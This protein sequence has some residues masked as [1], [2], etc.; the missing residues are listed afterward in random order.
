MLWEFPAETI[1]GEW[2]TTCCNILEAVFCRAFRTHHGILELTDVPVSKSKRRFGL[3]IMTPLVQDGIISSFTRIKAKVGPLCSPD[4]QIRHWSAFRGGQKKSSFVAAESPYFQR[5][6]NAIQR[7][8]LGDTSDLLTEIRTSL[9][10]PKKPKECVPEAAGPPFTGSLDAPIGFLL[11]F[12]AASPANNASPTTIK[13]SEKPVVMI[14]WPLQ[15]CH[16]NK[17]NCLVWT[18][19]FRAFTE[20]G[21]GHL[22]GS[23]PD[24]KVKDWHRLLLSESQAKVILLCGPR[25]EDIVR[26]VLGDNITRHKLAIWGF[27]H[28][29]YLQC[30]AE[31]QYRMY[32]RTPALP[33]ET[34]STS[35]GH[36]ARLNEAIKFS[37][38]M[39]GLR[40]IRPYFVE[41]TSAVGYIL[42]CA[43]AERLGE[44][45][46]TSKTIDDG[47]R[48]WLH[49]KGIPE[50]EDI[51]EIERLGG[52]LIRGLLMVLQALPRKNNKEEEKK[53]TQ[54][55]PQVSRGTDITKAER[56]RA[57]E[58][59]DQSCFQNA[60][61][62]VKERIEDR[63]LKYAVSLANLPPELL[64]L[65]ESP[66]SSTAPVADPGAP[67]DPFLDV[68]PVEDDNLELLG[69]FEPPHSS[70]AL[71]PEPEAPLEAPLA[72]SPVEEMDDGKRK[73]GT[74]SPLI[75]VPEVGQVAVQSP[76]VT[77]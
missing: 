28:S 65:F 68:P 12:A 47:I 72:S 48:L 35:V 9:L 62:L 5:D 74:A 16:F 43:R 8:A 69:L 52:T 38:N 32:V 10:E 57:H 73:R 1:K 77:K 2:Y 40:G 51:Q 33:S 63:G 49:R 58:R 75:Q 15:G 6:F 42:R 26:S 59:F 25:V 76:R 20:L 56:V 50:L 30:T 66:Q 70:T 21:L 4:C 29:M 46:M 14:P 23:K 3:N 60:K 45:P 41:S 39:V 54:L 55:Q 44:E 67:L 64:G 61:K 11:D 34:W 31:N 27:E 71:N 18:H 22:S 37:V 17:K 7:A 19:D 13:G 36:S 53:E 24:E